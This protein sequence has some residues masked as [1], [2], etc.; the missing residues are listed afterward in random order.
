MEENPRIKN[1]FGDLTGKPWKK[2]DFTTANG[3][4]TLARGKGEKVRGLKNRQHRPDYAGV[5]DFEND[6]NVE[7]P[8][9]VESGMRWLKR[10]VI[11]S[12]GAGDLS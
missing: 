6:E 5:D 3:V 12:M 7:N 4:R 1:D 10:A 8:R 11:G 9:L 2:N